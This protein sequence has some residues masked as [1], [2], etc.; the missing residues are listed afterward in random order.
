M[1]KEANGTIQTLDSIDVQCDHLFTSR[2]TSSGTS[3]TKGH[4]G[5]FA[6][7]ASV[8]F[9]NEGNDVLFTLIRILSVVKLMPKLSAVFNW[10][11]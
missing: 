7:N 6:P 5:S 1:V 3:I 9:L 11:N 4:T 10:G 8:K 2:T